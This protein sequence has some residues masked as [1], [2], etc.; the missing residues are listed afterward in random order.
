MFTFQASTKHPCSLFNDSTIKSTNK[1]NTFFFALSRNGFKQNKFNV[2]LAI[3]RMKKC[4]N[5]NAKVSLFP[6][7]SP[8]M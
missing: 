5:K 3:K 7:S 8:E 6:L 4:C 1:H 2:F